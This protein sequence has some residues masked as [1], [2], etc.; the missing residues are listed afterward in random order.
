M[1]S[2]FHLFGIN[3]KKRFE[4]MVSDG[5]V[6][7]GLIIFWKRMALCREALPVQEAE[8]ICN[9]LLERCIW[10]KRQ[11]RHARTYMNEHVIEKVSRWTVSYFK[12]GLDKGL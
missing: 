2:T 3:V 4:S 10:D 5:E 11:L 7:S 1:A 6:A 9:E 8:R 12:K